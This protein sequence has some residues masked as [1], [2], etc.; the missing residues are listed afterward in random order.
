MTTDIVPQILSAL[1]RVGADPNDGEEVRLRKSMLVLSTIMF[2]VAGLLW[3][4]MYFALRETAAGWIPFG[5]GIVSSISLMG[6]ALTHRYN[7]FR[8]SQLMLILLLPFLLMAA[9]GGFVNGSAVIIW[10]ILAP[11]GALVFDEPGRAPWWF[12]GY[13]GLVVLSGFL[14]PYVQRTNALSAQAVLLFFV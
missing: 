11:M 6:F 9:L 3:G 13:L 12:L 2:L 8:F 7:F 1:E 5:Y 10:A 14:E 4:V